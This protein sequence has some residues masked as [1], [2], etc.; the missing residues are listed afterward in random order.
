MTESK[1]TAD[2]LT[3]YGMLLSHMETLPDGRA[4]IF[5]RTETIKFICSMIDNLSDHLSR[6]NRI[7][8]ELGIAAFNAR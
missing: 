3:A 6:S 5:Y 1:T 7:N 2:P 4:E 8:R